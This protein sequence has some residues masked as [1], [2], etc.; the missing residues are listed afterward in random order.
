[1]YDKVSAKLDFISNELEVIDFWKKQD[2]FNKTL[3]QNEKGKYFSFYEGPPTANGMPHVGHPLTRAMKDIIPR[4]KTMKGFYVPRKAGWDT[5]GLPVEL[6]VEKNIGSTGKQDIEKFGVEKFTLLCKESVWKYKKIWEDITERFG[7][8]LDME[9]PYVTYENDYIESIF[10]ALKEMDKKG[11]IYKGHRISPYCPRCG[12]TLSKMEVEKNYKVLK[13]KSIFVKMKSL[14][15]E[16]TYFL[17]WTTTP[18]TLPSNIALCMNPKEKYVKIEYNGEFYILLKNLVSKHFEN[19]N[20]INTKTGK[21]YEFHKYEPLF[22]YYKN[23]IT[24]G[25]YVTVDNF[26]TLEDGTGI[27]HIAP[28]FGAEDYEVGQKYNLPFVQMIDDYGKFIDKAVHFKGMNAKQADKFIIEKLGKEN[29]LFKTELTEH[30]YPHCWRCETPLLYYAKSAWFV[31]TTAYK[32]KMIKNNKQVYWLPENI[33]EGRMGN[34]LENNIDWG[35]SRTRYWGTPLPFWECE[36]GHV[37]V[38]GSVQ[39]LKELSGIQE[40]NDLHKSELDKISFKCAECG[41]MM[42]RTPEVLDCWFDSGSMPFAQYH[43]PFENKEIFEKTFPADYICEGIDQTRGWFYT[44]LAV[45]TAIFEKLP[46]KSCMALGLVNDKFGLKMSKSKGN[47]IDPWDILNKQGADALR[48]YFYY[49]CTPGQNLSFNEENLQ[50]LQRKFMGTLWN[51]YAFYILYANI[52][53]FDPTK[54][55]LKNCKLAFIDK[56]LLSEFNALIKTVDAGLE[57]YIM[58]EPARKITDF[59]DNLSNWY[60]RRSRERF[61]ASGETNDKISAFKTLY[62]VLSGLVKLIA[63]FVPFISEKIYQNLVRSVEKN[64]PESVHLCEFPKADEKLINIELNNGM[65]DVLDIVVLGR[66]AR[67]SA[68]IKNRQP[69]SK[70]IV[71]SSGEL[72]LSNELVDLISGELNV[73]KV[74]LI[75]DEAYDYVT[76]ELKPQLKTL[77]PKYGKLIG[78][79]KIQLQKINGSDAVK[80]LKTGEKLKLNISGTEIELSESDLLIEIKNK[81]S[82]VSESNGNIT[83]ILDTHITQE[84]FE[85]GVTR[86]IISKIQSLRKESGFEVTDRII[87]SFSSDE[88]ISKIFEKFSE[89]IAKETLSSKIFDLNKT[90]FSEIKKEY[91]TDF[92]V[93]DS[94]VEIFVEKI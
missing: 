25:Y 27:V 50:E 41:K 79:I 73:E 67:N 55:Q 70:A 93:N 22:D 23:E 1:M 37:H 18:W 71:C 72:S 36:C 68:N 38:I 87:L 42:H 74:E 63:P 34:F 64:S 21:D 75:C 61:W 90:K 91:K 89:Q 48:W 46:F 19:Y 43:Y 66:S 3:K 59:V 92:I 47:G 76:Y 2:I 84:L 81:E 54:Y 35:I 39:E 88:I 85:K 86:E 44:L 24:D 9:K 56:W 28:A 14:E 40:I 13:E 26:V 5:H 62:T 83:V 51:V 49:A 30:S 33:R 15:E 31:K 10:W 11:L 6:E 60:I 65:Q 57:K 53:N 58:L 16:N 45:N 17:V 8:W 69:L 32:D 29:K 77:G 4:F 82:F 52:D 7:Y 78:E 94:K 20:L 12:T 80:K